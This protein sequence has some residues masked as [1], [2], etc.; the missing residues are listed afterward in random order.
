M[1]FDYLLLTLTVVGLWTPAYVLL[2]SFTKQKI[3]HC[4]RRDEGIGTLLASPFNWLDLARSTGCT[5]ILL[6]SVFDFEKGQ[7]ELA[8]VFTFVRLAI[9]GI[10]VLLQTIWFGRQRCVIGPVFFLTGICLV[11]AGLAVGGFGLA[12]ALTFAMKLRRLSFVFLI[13]PVCLAAFG[14][15]FGQIGLNTVASSGFFALPLFFAF[16]INTRLS[17]VRRVR[18]GNVSH[19]NAR[20]ATILASGHQQMTTELSA[21]AANQ[22]TV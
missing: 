18:T 14:V 4:R 10:G 1:N 12:L 13:A 3:A 7:D 8:L 17:F 19:K 11:L 15:F 22:H 9:L 20:S 21:G 6:N 5:W 16:A 2:P